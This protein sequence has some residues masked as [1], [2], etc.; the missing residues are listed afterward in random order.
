MPSSSGG[1]VATPH[2]LSARA[3]AEILQA[4]GNA[5]D[6]AIAA[7]AVQG[8]VAPETCGVGGDLFAL[9]HQPGA[10]TPLALNASGRAGAGV[11]AA[12]LRAAGHR[13]IPRSHPGAI[14]VPG[15]V[16]GWVALSSRLGALPLASVLAPAIR[17]ATDGFPASDELVLAFQGSRELLADQEAAAPMFAATSVG[18]P[19]VRAQLARTLRAVA[20]GGREAFYGGAAGRAIIDA[21]GGVITADDLRRDQADWVEAL[22]VDAWGATGWTVPPNSQGYLGIGACVVLER[23]GWGAD[24]AD[25]RDWHLMIEAHRALAAERDGVVVDPSL[26]PVDLQRLLDP[27]RMDAVAAS[28]DPGRAR[29]RHPPALAA[30]GTAYLCVLDASGLGVSL[31]QSN[32]SGLGSGVGAG[33]A[34]FLLHDRGRGFNLAA[35]HPGELAP[36][37]RPMH[38]LSPTLWTRDD[39]LALLL[40]TRGGHVQPQLILQLAAWVLGAGLDPDVA[41]VRGRWT[42][43]LPAQ[44]PSGSHVRVEPDVPAR[45]VD[46]LRRLGHEVEPVDGPQSGWGP[47]SLIRVDDDGTRLSARDP[48]VE[49][50]AVITA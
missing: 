9:V 34:G 40:G 25:P 50:T 8:V 14:P 44:R 47:V 41:Q 1:V 49:T 30:G 35:G 23:L 26:V 48:R 46:G 18:S 24:P 42:V 31:I 20:D 32:F 33:A 36:G 29:D 28:V 5:V 27:A 17:L 13:E 10:A 37:R 7:C 12:S 2:T 6:A 11:D 16:D 43:A 19:V 45:V 3:G 39:D 15:C 4:G 21:V 22:S 38:T